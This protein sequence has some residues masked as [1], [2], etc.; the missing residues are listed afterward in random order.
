MTVRQLLSHTSGIEPGTVLRQSPSSSSA[1]MTRAILAAPLLGEAGTVFAYGGSSM[2]IAA[3]ISERKTG[4]TWDQL[5]RARL[6]EPLGFTSPAWR[7]PLAPG[8]QNEAGS[9]QVA[10]GLVLSLDDLS[11]FMTMILNRGR[12][13]ERRILSEAAVAEIERLHTG[14][15]RDFRRLPIAKPDWRYGLGVWC[16]AYIASGACSVSSS[17]GA[18]GTVPWVDRTRNRAGVF[19]TRTRLPLVL[20]GV[21]DLR[22]LSHQITRDSPMNSGAASDFLQTPPER[23]ADLPDF[24]FAARGVNVGE[25]GAP[26]TM[27]YLDEGPRDGAVIVLVHG[28]PTW[29]YL[30]RRMIPPLTAAGFRVI[31]PDLIGYGRSDKPTRPEAY[32]YALQQERLQRFFDAVAPRGA[33]L[34]VHDW[35][36]LLG[37]PIAARD[38]DRFARLVILDTSLNDGSDV[39]APA[40]S[41]GFDRW[42]ALLQSPTPIPWGEIIRRRT[43]RAMSD[44]EAAAY[45]APF[46]D[47][48]FE[49][50][51]R[52]M[53]ALIPRRREDPGA[54]ENAA[55]RAALRQ[56]PGH[57]L[58]AFSQRS[59]ETHPGQH[60]L[61]SNL[62]PHARIWRDVTLDGA[63]HFSPEDKSG[64]LAA[65]IITFHAETAPP[66]RLQR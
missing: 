3:A 10:G 43:V 22:A 24:P 1:D 20:D 36:G 11:T 6:A 18:F 19:I 23:F 66:A 27:S 65:L 42:L 54:R 8:E 29:S 25:A 51:P 37:L 58:I 17:A 26:L 32:T 38:L 30:W 21:L 12:L 47:R 39:E 50:G 63:A 59:A 2:Q 64:E 55:A 45:M 28:Q 40:F 14:S 60:T 61:F 57:V 16:E 35:G 48:S 5:F 46:P 53:S 52:S 7:H 15:V 41:A 33:T 9:P 44:A 4:Q 13:G 49:T 62:F 34:V 56:F 31:A